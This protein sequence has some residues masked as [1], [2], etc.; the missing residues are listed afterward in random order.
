MN[1]LSY[2]FTFL[3]KRCTSTFFF[4]A[5]LLLAFLPFKSQAQTAPKQ[6]GLLWEIT[7]NGLKKPSYVYGTMH[8]SSKLAFHLGDSFFKAMMSCETVAFEQNF[9]SVIHLWITEKASAKKAD[10]EV[11]RRR[12][13]GYFGLNYFKLNTFNKELVQDRL[14]SETQ[15]ANYILKRGDDDNFEEDAWL[16]LYIYQMAKRTGKKIAGVEGYEE[17][18]KLVDEAYN[19]EDEDED[20][21][22]NKKKINYSTRS[23]LSAK[24]SPSYRKGEIWML[25]S[26]NR[27][28]S[29][30]HYLEYMLYKRNENQVRRMDSIMKLGRTLFT[31][32]GC[33]HL[34]GKRGVLMLLES[35]GY[36]VKPINSIANEKSKLAEKYEKLNY[37]H[38][39]TTIQSNDGFISA[40]LPSRLSKVKETSEFE[41]YFCPDLANG[42]FYQIDKI[43]T[44]TAFTGKPINEI[45]LQIDS[46]LYES[47]P[48]KI[49][50][51][52][53]ISNNSMEGY[54]IVSRLKTGDVQRF[55]IIAS[56]FHLYII[57]IAGKQEFAL[58]KAGDNFFN[59]LKINEYSATVIKKLAAPDSF[60]SVE[61]PTSIT[62][63][64]FPAYNKTTGYLEHLA[65]NPAENAIYMVQ[66]VDILNYKMME[67]D[68]FNLHIMAKSFARTDNYDIENYKLYELQGYRTMDATFTN[69]NKEHFE[70]RFIAAGRRHI[71]FVQKSKSN[72]KFDSR[73]FKSIVINGAYP[74]T[75]PFEYKD[76]SLFYTVQTTIKPYLVVE[77]E[78]NS[79]KKPKKIDKSEG[80]FIEHYFAPHN[81]NEF[82]EVNF[83]QFGR[84][85]NI[86]TF[87]DYSKRSEKE[88]QGAVLAYK[89]KYHKNGAEYL[90]LKFAD[91]GTTRQIWRMRVRKGEVSY[92]IYS[93]VDTIKPVSAFIKNFYNTF[94]PSSDTIIGTNV[95]EAKGYRIVS[96]IKTGDSL[97]KK[98]AY[99]NIS[100]SEYKL[101]DAKGLIQ[102]IDSL[103]VPVKDYQKRKVDLYRALFSIKNLDAPSL[104]Y[105]LN[106][107]TKAKDTAAYIHVLLNGLSANASTASYEV[108]R[109]ILATD[110]PVVK[111]NEYGSC[112]MFSNMSDTAVLSK[113]FIPLFIEL[114][115]IDEY[116]QPVYKLLSAM[117]DSNLIN[118]KDI[119]P[120]LPKLITQAKINLKRQ[121]SNDYSSNSG[122]LYY[123]TNIMGYAKESKPEIQTFL[124][125]IA[126]FTT[127]SERKIYLPLM[128]KHNV[129][130]Q[131][132]VIQSMAKDKETRYFIF[133]NLNKYK[134]LEK[135]PSIYKNQKEIAIA[136]I[137]PTANSYNKIDSVI[138]MG[139]RTLVINNENKIVYLFKTHAED[140][141]NNEWEA[142]ASAPFHKNESLLSP[143]TNVSY[144]RQEI[145][146]TVTEEK[147]F[148]ELLFIYEYTYRKLFNGLNVNARAFD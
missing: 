59:S 61:I 125:E 98:S 118:A 58:S 132:S 21:S 17:S 48:G 23:K 12:T 70:G 13:N 79:R 35:M 123:L 15:V 107:Y 101:S 99:E 26:I 31:A 19:D 96:D 84:Y 147:M 42:H 39:Y 34:P 16:D 111:F 11:L 117:L 28:I 62:E 124:S 74:E 126:A 94:S 25:D 89:K 46:I 2:N 144:L 116:R 129:P 137:Y 110:P 83:Y 71:M 40:N 14:S 142:Y 146:E 95:Y 72:E 57:R 7:G 60:F 140:D 122:N 10:N 53:N 131:D 64:K 120:Y 49:E 6:K 9:D 3:A 51:K 73:F 148:N 90:M 88:P 121:K 5:I 54:E 135:F 82:I 65:F 1:L 92:H 41:T 86:D 105:A 18:R 85:D 113:P 130:V 81:A 22:K 109:K 104:Q 134:Q 63:N 32:V 97:T 136:M 30:E 20:N 80:I 143:M 75:K 66:Q 77:N 139:S 8:V 141:A 115:E 93:V 127:K 37:K 128:L 119:S 45:L 145:P 106:S 27:T 24:I 29:S 4:S 44:Y 38:T 78:R 102:L 100:E 76:T 87:S 67:D 68:T 43:N 50:S 108:I 56:P 36:K 52:K 138:F 133:Y 103:N 33:A 112:R 47:I 69:K 91:T 55:R 114:L